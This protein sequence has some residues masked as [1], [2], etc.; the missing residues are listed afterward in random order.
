[1]ILASMD[2]TKPKFQYYCRSFQV[3]PKDEI[4]NTHQ[5]NT[6]GVGFQE[7]TYNADIPQPKK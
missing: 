1:M 4:C 7:E 5:V 3:N 6:H 2:P